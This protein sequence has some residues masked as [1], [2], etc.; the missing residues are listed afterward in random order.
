MAES[1]QGMMRIIA[2]DHVAV[3]KMLCKWVRT[4]KI[5]FSADMWEDFI[6]LH[7]EKQNASIIDG[8]G[9]GIAR[10]KSWLSPDNTTA[11]QYLDRWIFSMH[12]A[13]TELRKQVAEKC[14]HFAQSC[15]QAGRRHATAPG[16]E[17]LHK[18]AAWARAVAE[19]P[20]IEPACGMDMFGAAADAGRERDD[21]RQ[22]SQAAANLAKDIEDRCK[23]INWLTLAAVIEN[24]RLAFDALVRRDPKTSYKM[25][26]RTLNQWKKC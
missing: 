19:I 11:E 7:P 1:E 22:K 2:P 4:A 15:D 14:S 8:S 3:L 10:L 5:D 26:N 6:L 17:I 25:L 18:L 24:E 23:I 20:S 9:M 13:P 12:D 21:L 16:S